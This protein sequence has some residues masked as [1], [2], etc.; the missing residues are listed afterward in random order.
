MQG[1][2]SDST[3]NS[4]LE[5]VHRIVDR[6]RA[7]LARVDHCTYDSSETTRK[8]YFENCRAVAEEAI[9]CVDEIEWVLDALRPAELESDGAEDV[10]YFAV[11]ELRAALEPIVTPSDDG[12]N[13]AVRCARLLGTI[14]RTMV[15][16]ERELCSVFGGE[17]ELGWAL[18]PGIALETRQAYAAFRDA[19]ASWGRLDETPTEAIVRSRLQVGK[20]A[21]QALKE[22]PVWTRFRMSDRI[23][24]LKLESRVGRWLASSHVTP[25]QGA[26][27]WDDLVAFA[28]LLEGINMRQELREFDRWMA[29]EM[30]PFLTDCEPDDEVP[31]VVK[32]LAAELRWRSSEWDELFTGSAPAGQWLEAFEQLANG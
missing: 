2:G 32:D 26:A 23:E 20:A 17:P 7:L 31:P 30:L 21:I 25:G 3:E 4:H 11:V 27:I 1:L 29:Q 14:V 8:S 6:A 10:L 19:I 5:T 12:G 24:F 18:E 9:A 13:D 28:E 16:V 22:A 15:T